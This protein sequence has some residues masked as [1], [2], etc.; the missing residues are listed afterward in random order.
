MTRIRYNKNED[1]SILTTK[2]ITCGGRTLTVSLVL[3]TMTYNVVCY[4]DGSVVSTGQATN[5]GKL[6]KQAKQELARL[7]VNF[8]NEVRMKE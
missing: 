6:K 8:E 3:A 4:D 2:P 5:L 1:G 7:G